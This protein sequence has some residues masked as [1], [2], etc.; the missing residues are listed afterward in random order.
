MERDAVRRASFVALV[1]LLVVLAGCTGITPGGSAGQSMQTPTTA[2]DPGETTE[3][4]PADVTVEPAGLSRAA[5]EN[6]SDVLSAN[7]RALV[8][9]GYI[10]AVRLDGS[11]R[12]GGRT[13]NLSVAQREVVEPGLTAFTYQVQK[14]VAS[15]RTS[16][17]VWSNRSTAVLRN[18]RGDQTNYRRIDRARITSQLAATELFPQ[19]V[20]AGN[21]TL[22]TT[23]QRDNQTVY[24]FRAT[25]YTSQV[26][27]KMPAPENVTTYRGRFAVDSMGRIRF[28][29][30]A[31][32]Y[33]GPRGGTAQIRIKYVLQQ[34]GDVSVETPGW[35]DEAISSSGRNAGHHQGGGGGGGHHAI[36]GGVPGTSVR[37]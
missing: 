2:A 30:V 1:S 6:T 14:E 33:D 27:A 10:A 31:M 35:V 8:S 3:G 29:D 18:R 17:I 32:Q 19:Y 36:G 28:I 12:S 16:T 22:A 9:T 7:R 24:V 4:P 23:T 11:I 5:I 26:G 21:Y 13:R 34:T 20:A 15:T 37:S 25:E